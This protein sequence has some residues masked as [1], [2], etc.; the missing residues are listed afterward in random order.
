MCS[1]SSAAGRSEELDGHPGR[2]PLAT[3]PEISSSFSLGKG[4]VLDKTWVR[5]E[6]QSQIRGRTEGVP[7]SNMTM[8]SE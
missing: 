6:I 8:A 5:N 7:T 1:H 4:V 3:I 2:N